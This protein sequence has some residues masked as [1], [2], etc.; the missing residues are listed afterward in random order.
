MLRRLVP[1]QA[2]LGKRRVKSP[3]VYVR[4]SGG[5]RGASR[6]PP[7]LRTGST[8][9]RGPYRIPPF[10][11]DLP[12]SLR[13]GQCEGLIESSGRN[14]LGIW[15]NGHVNLEGRPYGSPEFRVN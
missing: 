4:D 2:N 14:I 1:W 12:W 7:R 5:R 3:K 8:A 9:G 10:R 6:L 15:E 13:F 11:W